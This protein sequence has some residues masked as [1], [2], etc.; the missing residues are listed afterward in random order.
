[1]KTVTGV[2]DKLKTALPSLPHD[3]SPVEPLGNLQKTSDRLRG[4]LNFASTVEEKYD[5]GLSVSFTS[6]NVSFPGLNLSFLSF[7][8]FGTK[9]MLSLRSG[10]SK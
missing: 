3:P 6:A 7:H 8:S 2:F 4:L 10:S 1:M 5:V 9:L